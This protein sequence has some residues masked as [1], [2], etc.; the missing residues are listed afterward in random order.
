MHLRPLTATR[1]TTQAARKNLKTTQATINASGV[2]QRLSNP[3]L[4]AA[5]HMLIGSRW[6]IFHRLSF[7][8]RSHNITGALLADCTLETT[9]ILLPA[10][11]SQSGWA[12][13]QVLL[14]LVDKVLDQTASASNGDL[15][16]HTQVQASWTPLTTT[17]EVKI[18]MRMKK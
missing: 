9:A 11:Y 7:L 15:R 17:A 5:I 16:R 1:Q 3:T 13:H 2:L 18:S 12:R 10:R 14:N 4:R 8:M 6:A